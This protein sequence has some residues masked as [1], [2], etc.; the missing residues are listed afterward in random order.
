MQN[1]VTFIM[2]LKMGKYL[3]LILWRFEVKHCFKY[4]LLG[5]IKKPFISPGES[6]S[7]N[8]ETTNIFQFQQQHIQSRNLMQEI[9]SINICA[10]ES[11]PIYTTSVNMHT[12]GPFVVIS[13][14]IRLLSCNLI[15]LQTVLLRSFIWFQNLDGIKIALCLLP[16]PGAVVPLY[17]ISLS[18]YVWGKFL[19]LLLKC[20][21]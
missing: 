12:H 4:S 16:L 21:F 9:K 18:L 14:R 19:M 10:S 3:N 11:C 13:Y 7:S 6:K 15:V 17:H 5:E 2:N 8:K 1:P 20:V